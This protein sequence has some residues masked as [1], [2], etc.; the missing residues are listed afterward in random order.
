[1]GTIAKVTAGGATHLVAS[2]AYATCST[3]AATA[4]KVATIQDSQ[5]F[6]LVTGVTIHVYFSEANTAASPTL[7]VN[8]TGAKP[9]KI[10]GATGAG[11]SSITSWTAGNLLALTYNGTNWIIN[12]FNVYPSSFAGKPTANQTPGFGDTFTIQQISQAVGGQVSGT[13]RTVTIPNA[14]ATTSAAGLMSAADKSN[15]NNLVNNSPYI[16]IVTLTAGQTSVAGPAVDDVISHIAID[17]TTHEEV[18]VDYTTASN[19][20]AAGTF[21][22]ASAYTHDIEIR[23]V[24]DE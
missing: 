19:V 17:K 22:I 2:T 23:C 13:D 5:A 9:I 4:A 8:S 21:S 14:T 3:P 12:S 7:N 16:E 1:M 24:C 11:S 10:W 18:V 15:L 6:T 20:G